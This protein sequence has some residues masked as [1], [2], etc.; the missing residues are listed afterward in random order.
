MALTHFD[1]STENNSQ[2]LFQIGP[3]GDILKLC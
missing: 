2:I 3:F 1:L